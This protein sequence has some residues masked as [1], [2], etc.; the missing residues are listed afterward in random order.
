M[1][2]RVVRTP[3]RRAASRSPPSAYRCFPN[4]VCRATYQQIA[5]KTPMI[6]SSA[7]TPAHLSMYR[8]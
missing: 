6:T 2:I 8:L 3:A 4:A 1:L 7:G 5:Q